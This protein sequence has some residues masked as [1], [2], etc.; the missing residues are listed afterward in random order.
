MSASRLRLPAFVRTPAGAVGLFLL[1][2]VLAVALL[3][4]LVAPH[5]ITA[6]VGAPAAGPSS[7]APLGTDYLGRDVLSRLLHGGVTVVLLATATTAL[8]Y[9]V[10]ATIG[11]V[12][13]YVKGLLDPILMRSVD[14]V[15]VFPALLLLLLLSTGLGTK[16]WVVVVGVALVQIPGI[17]RV[18]RTATLEQST[19]GYVEAANVRGEKTSTLITRELLPNVA[20][21]LLADFGIRFASSIVLIASMNYLGLG[22]NPPA[23]DWGLMISENRAYMGLNFWCV[24][25]PAILL[26]LLTISVNMVADAYVRTQGRSRGK[27]RRATS[28]LSKAGPS[29]MVS[30]GAAGEGLA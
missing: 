27:S 24:L 13:G 10:G 20:P 28:K 26:G 11:L 4:P 14:V 21:I 7:G 25:A 12:A 30:A 8:A 29:E 5:P 1:L 15:L 22:L 3:G 23:A 17:A 18:V 9:L 6:V 16:A 19:R 2:S